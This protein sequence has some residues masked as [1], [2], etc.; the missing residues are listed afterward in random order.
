MEQPTNFS[1]IGDPN[2]PTKKPA[3]GIGFSSMFGSAA[4]TINSLGGAPAGPT[5]PTGPTAPAPPA[6]TAPATQMP[7]MSASAATPATAPAAPSTMDPNA[8]WGSLTNQ[9]QT[10][11]GRAMTPEEA[12]ALQ[13]Y[14]GYSGGAINQGMIDKATQGISAYTGN[15]ANPFGPATPATPP[16]PTAATPTPSA[17]TS[18]TVQ[19][20]LQQMLTTGQTAALNPT[21]LNNPAMEAQRANFNR[22]NDRTRGRERLA[23]SERAA[24]RNG[25]GSGGYDANLA[26]I[27]QAAGDRAVGF[28]SQLMAGELQG[29]RDRVMQAMQMATA[30]GD[31]SQARDLQERLATIDNQL[32]REGMTAQNRLGQ[33]QLNLGLLQ[34]LMGDRRAGDALGF[35]YAALGQQANQGLLNS[36]LSQM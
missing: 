26:G 28:E 1:A 25:L 20:Q 23:A 29:Q 4:P 22:V 19:Q 7:T 2:N 36:I 32:R 16:A 30:S 11:F 3:S 35:N 24:A 15:I 33:G 18:N 14:A 5:A 31:A 17:Q 21:E 10:K 13:G 8:V 27:E 34:A 12:K 9:F 6:P